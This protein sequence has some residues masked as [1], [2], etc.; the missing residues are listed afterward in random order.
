MHIGT[1]TI[2]IKDKPFH[3]GPISAKTHKKG[4]V[5]LNA[6]IKNRESLQTYHSTKYPDSKYSGGK[7]CFYLKPFILLQDKLEWTGFQ[8]A[9]IYYLMDT[10]QYIFRNRYYIVVRKYQLKFLAMDAFF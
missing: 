10:L 9:N 8:A 7:S 1:C 6:H 4:K 2:D 3:L 5:N